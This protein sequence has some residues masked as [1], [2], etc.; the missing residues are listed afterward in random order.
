MTRVNQLLTLIGVTVV[1]TATPL[2]AAEAPAI[3]PAAEQIL[4]RMG[5]VLAGAES[6]TVRN[7]FTSD[8]TVT[9]GEIVQL[10][11]TVE[12]AARRPDRLR[13][14]IRGDFGPKEYWFDGERIVFMD[15]LSNTYATAEVSPTIDDALD[16]MWE[17]FGIKIP[18]ADFVVS[19]PHGDLVAR[20]ES[21]FYAGLH[22]AGGVSC[23]H[24]VFTQDDI[25][26][27][28]WIEDGLLPLPRKLVITYKTEDGYP[29]YEAVFSDWN[30]SPGLNDAVFEFVPPVG[31]LEIE[32]AER[33]E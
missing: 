30:L 1:V 8:E 18:L 11:G 12:I 2:T 20:V 3:D 25:D 10:A 16:G 14:V 26:W 33:T 5:A 15:R 21:G 13:A 7:D 9:T 17:N 6:F 4:E 29:Q 31:A 23:H 24:L 19:D 32:F 27:Q 28:I 22:T